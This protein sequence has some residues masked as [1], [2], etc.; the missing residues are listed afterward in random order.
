MEQHGSS[1]VGPL[2]RGRCSIGAEREQRGWVHRAVFI[3]LAGAIDPV[4]VALVQLHR[5]APRA[6]TA[7]RRRPSCSLRRPGRT[8][9]RRTSTPCS[10]LSA[11]ARPRHHGQHRARVE[12]LQRRGW[13]RLPCSRTGATTPAGPLELTRVTRTATSSWHTARPGPAPCSCRA[14]PRPRTASR[15]AWRG[16]SAPA[17]VALP[18]GSPAA[19]VIS[20]SRSTGRVAS[21]S[22]ARAGGAAALVHGGEERGAWLVP[23]A[24][25][26]WDGHGPRASA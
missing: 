7:G 22:A 6:R 2:P 16:V 20:G 17:S 4:Q 9:P 3:L 11:P 8:R 25:H 12:D 14:A 24:H 13:A 18:S 26:C 1:N 19:A 23:R 10:H 21:K 15:A 5:A